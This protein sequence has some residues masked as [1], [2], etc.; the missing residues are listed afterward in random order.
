M[1]VTPVISYSESHIGGLEFG[2]NTEGS[3]LLAD[4]FHSRLDK[5]YWNV[6]GCVRLMGCKLLFLET[7]ILFHTVM[8]LGSEKGMYLDEHLQIHLDTFSLKYLSDLHSV[9]LSS[10]SS[11]S[12]HTSFYRQLCIV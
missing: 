7:G 9:H 4:R 6:H 1:D 11:N 5:L 3:V 2:N 8:Q 10:T 12:S